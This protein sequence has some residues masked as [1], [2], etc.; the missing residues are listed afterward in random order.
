MRYRNAP[1]RIPGRRG[2]HR[3]PVRGELGV[4]TYS[5][6]Q[7]QRELA[8]KMIK[9]LKT[10]FV[11]V[12]E[13]HLPYRES[14]EALARGRKEFDEAGLQVMSGGVMGRESKGKSVA[15]NVTEG[16][17]LDKVLK[18]NK[19]LETIWN[20]VAD[21]LGIVDKQVAVISAGSKTPQ[22]GTP[23]P[24]AVFNVAGVDFDWTKIA[25][26]AAA[27]LLLVWLFTRKKGK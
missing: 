17:E 2:W 21:R 13:F 25:L 23:Q 22:E 4:A 20:A 10:P 19:S 24:A 11:C 27:A 16:T 1:P 8:I 7:F 15:T 5:F 6:R 12:K 26:V 18:K 3:G 14:P 9:E